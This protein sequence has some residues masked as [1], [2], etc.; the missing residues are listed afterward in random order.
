[1]LPKILIVVGILFAVCGFVG[2][3]ALSIQ[4]FFKAIRVVFFH[5]TDDLMYYT[6]HGRTVLEKEYKVLR[7]SFV[8]FLFMGF[9]CLITGVLL[10]NA[11]RGEDSLF[12]EYVDGAATGDD[13]IDSPQKQESGAAGKD[14]YSYEI[15][16]SEKTIYCNGQKM[17]SIEGF[18]ACIKQLDRRQGIFLKDDF[19][20]SSTYHKVEELLDTYGMNY[21]TE[22]DE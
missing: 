2:L 13:R 14:E 22:S 5:S 7:R 16:I 18:E 3:I 8:F 4:P 10:K 9:I 15:L 6:D 21:E 19:A 20:V 12:S 17:D 11:P 1:M